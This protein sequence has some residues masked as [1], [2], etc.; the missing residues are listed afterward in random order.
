MFNHSPAT[1]GLKKLL[2]F[3]CVIQQIE[4]SFFVS[5]INELID[6]FK[7]NQQIQAR[8]KEYIEG[9][10][11]RL[12]R[13]MEFTNTELGIEE[14][15]LVKSMD[16]KKYI[17]HCQERGK[18]ANI[19]MN[20]SIA[21]LRVFFQYLVDEEF[22][23][24]KDNPMK[25]IKNLKEAKRVII[26]FNDEEVKRIINSV[27]EETYSNVRD[28]L[29]LIM[30]FDTGIR[31]SELCNIKNSDATRTNILIHGKGSKERLIYI[32]K[33]MRRYMRRYEELKKERFK[34]RLDDEIEDYYFLDQSAEKLSR[35]RINKILKEHCKNAKVRKEVRC[36]PHDC[37]HYFAQKQ[38]KNGIDVYSLSRLM[39]HF[40]TQITAKYLRGLEQTEILEIGKLYSPLGKVKI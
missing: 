3:I 36:S 32:S 35:S 34:H 16:I 28:K 22:I 5:K 25:R 10:M 7:M 31:V 12:R 21:T 2:S 27:A 6:D 9:C 40:D 30:L 18:E 20:G 11:Y 17:L 13:W 1:I 26:T 33:V 14:A 24:E 29:I 4:G 8:K 19:T 39:G 37:R 23:D 15:E 38:L